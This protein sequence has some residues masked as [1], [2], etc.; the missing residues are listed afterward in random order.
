MNTPMT[1]TRTRKAGRS[2]R[3]RNT[4]QPCTS[5]NEART[6]ELGDTEMHVDRSS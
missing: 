6:L 4:E 3:D 1:V 5:R 2:K